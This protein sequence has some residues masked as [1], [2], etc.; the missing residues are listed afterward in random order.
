[1]PSRKYSSSSAYRYGF[2]GKENDNE[3]KGEGN[4]QDYGFRIYD[5]RISKFL[6]VDPLANKFP[7][8][9]PYQFA[10]NTPIVAIDLD[11]LEPKVSTNPE[12]KGK[13]DR[14]WLV[15]EAYDRTGG[16][17]KYSKSPVTETLGTYVRQVDKTKFFA[18]SD[19]G[20][21]NRTVN[22]NSQFLFT[23]ENAFANE[24]DLVNH[25][26]GNFVWGI[27]PENYVFPENGKFSSLLKGSIAVGES[28]ADW[29]KA[30]KQDGVYYWG[31]DLR[32]QTNVAM[33][34][35]ITSIEQFIGSCA[36]KITTINEEHI[37]IEI[38]NVTSL[39]SGD[40][41]KDLP[42]IKWFNDPLKSVK[43]DGTTDAQV[44][45]SNVSQHFS[46][47][48]SKSEADKLIN[49]FNPKGNVGNVK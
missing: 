30:G 5:P 10:G 21:A 49:Q 18:N 35:G 22:E 28:L 14:M 16:D 43:R 38:F 20:G 1:M 3:V 40:I 23:K 34:S 39:T 44:D 13:E 41:N 9:T 47:T 48:I 15:D 2:N 8:Y 24:E 17:D 7:Y 36:V 12:L 6:S 33:S 27:G 26:L 32:G 46:L 29:G 19:G 4:Q 37:K 25:M 31:M 11:G 42:I 45:H